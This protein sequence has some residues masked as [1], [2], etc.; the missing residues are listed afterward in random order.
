MCSMKAVLSPVEF[1]HVKLRLLQPDDLPY[2]LAWRNEVDVRKWFKFSGVVSLEQHL[3]WFEKYQ[4]KDDDFVFMALHSQTNERLGQL[5]IYDVDSTLRQA[6]VGRF[7][8]APAA[9]GKGFMTDAL[10][11]LAQ[12]AERQLKL[13]RL[14]LEVFS[15]NA[16]AIRLYERV[17]YQDCGATGDLVLMEVKLHTR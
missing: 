7:I 10:H 3:V 1:G 16:R 14:F 9:A 12:I 15:S 6:E 13:S 5:A 17:G 4:L 8:A 2:T 11:G